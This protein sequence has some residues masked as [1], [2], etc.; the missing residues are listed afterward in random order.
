[1]YSHVNHQQTF[2]DNEGYEKGSKA[3][4]KDE[5]RSLEISENRWTLPRVCCGLGG[6]LAEK[7]AETHEFLRS[8]AAFCLCERTQEILSTEISIIP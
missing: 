4:R 7:R 1:M 2:F 3:P 8:H 5:P 6:I